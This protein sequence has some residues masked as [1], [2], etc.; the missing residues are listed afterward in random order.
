MRRF[1]IPRNYIE[2]AHQNDLDHSPIEIT[3]TEHVEMMWQF[4]DIELLTLIRPVESVSK[5][6]I[7]FSVNPKLSLFQN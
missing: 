7:V 2:R 5:N 6:K 3:A 1:S 4:V